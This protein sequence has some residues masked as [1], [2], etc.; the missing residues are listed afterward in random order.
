MVAPFP[1]RLAKKPKENLEK[2]IWETFRKVQV[3]IP[4]LDAI[5]QIPR[6]AK[7]LKDL[8]TNKRKLNGN[9]KVTLSENASAVIQRKLP[10]KCKDK[11]SFS[12]PIRLGG[13]RTERAMCDLGASINVLPYSTYLTLGLG[14]LTETGVIIQ[15]ADRSYVYPEGV[16]EDVLVQVNDLIFPADFYVLRMGEESSANSASIL[17]GRPFLRTARA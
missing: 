15:L 13:S 14:P 3:N 16:L 10:P 17:L 2:D 8:C 6:Y 11:G 12:I 9:E 7:F 5:K 4:L 1:S